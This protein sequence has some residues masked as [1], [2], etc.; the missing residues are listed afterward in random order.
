MNRITIGG[1]WVAA[2]LFVPLNNFGL[3]A[4]DPSTTARV[5]VE[6]PK[7]PIKEGDSLEIQCMGDGTASSIPIITHNTV[8]VSRLL[9]KPTWSESNV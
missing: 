2:L 7:G 6:S 3:S 5:W 9:H 8:R 4:S 1:V